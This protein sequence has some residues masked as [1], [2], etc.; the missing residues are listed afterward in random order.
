M[1]PDAEPARGFTPTTVMTFK[2]HL[3]VDSL[4]PSQSDRFRLSK[5]HNTRSILINR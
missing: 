2:P 1:L 3:R 5:L 4:F